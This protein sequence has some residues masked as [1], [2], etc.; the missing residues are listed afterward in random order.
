MRRHGGRL[1]CGTGRV[2]RAHRNLTSLMRGASGSSVYFYTGAFSAAPPTGAATLLANDKVQDDQ[3]TDNRVTGAALSV[4]TAGLILDLG[5]AKFLQGFRHTILFSD[6]ITSKTFQYWDGS[7]WQTGSSGAWNSP[8]AQGGVLGYWTAS[9][10]TVAT[11]ARWWKIEI[12]V[13]DVSSQ[14]SVVGFSD[15]RLTLL[16]GASAE[17][18]S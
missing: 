8:P 13:T 3:T 9:V 14:P 12:A 10:L 7:A 16:G 18:P 6:Q 17:L 2:F 5:A 11:A 15:I 1:T 4:Q